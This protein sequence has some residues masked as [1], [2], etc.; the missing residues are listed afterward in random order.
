MC[1]ETANPGSVL[2]Y[3]SLTIKEGTMKDPDKPLPSYVALQ[4]RPPQTAG[5]QQEVWATC[6]DVAEWQRPDDTQPQWQGLG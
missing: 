5:A 6:R 2:L 3:T 4:V 1:R